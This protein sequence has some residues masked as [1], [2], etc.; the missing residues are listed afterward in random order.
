MLIFLF[1]LGAPGFERQAMKANENE[2]E[3]AWKEPKGVEEFKGAF[4][5]CWSVGNEFVFL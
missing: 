4:S 3:L 1:V 5:R 2:N